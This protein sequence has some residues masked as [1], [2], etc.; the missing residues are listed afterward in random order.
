M[1]CAAPGAGLDGP[2]GSLPTP[3]IL[4][5]HGDN[6]AALDHGRERGRACSSKPSFTAI[7]QCGSLSMQTDRHQESRQQT[8]MDQDCCLPSLVLALVF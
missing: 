6:Q 2:H 8:R 1:T 5:F 7:C 4:R 3:D